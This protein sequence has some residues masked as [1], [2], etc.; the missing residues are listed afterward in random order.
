[1]RIRIVGLTGKTLIGL[2]DRG[3]GRINR[4]YEA[5]PRIQRYHIRAISP[6]LVHVMI[7]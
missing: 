7:A 4:A 2:R 3:W 5:D 6:T 1:M